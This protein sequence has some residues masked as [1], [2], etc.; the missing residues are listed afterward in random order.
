MTPEEEQRLRVLMAQAQR[1]PLPPEEIFKRFKK[2]KSPGRMEGSGYVRPRALMA[3]RLPRGA[4]ER[5]YKKKGPLKERK[6][7]EPVEKRPVGRPKKIR[8]IED[9]PSR[10]Q[11]IP[12]EPK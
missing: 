1:L 4:V 10:Y 6:V 11:I 9:D 7:K 3:S 8:Q 2:V 5:F 12:Y